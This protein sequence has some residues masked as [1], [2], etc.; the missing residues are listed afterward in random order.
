MSGGASS[1]GL[2]TA[3]VNYRLL[4]RGSAMNAPCSL[5]KARHWRATFIAPDSLAA[6][7]VWASYF[8]RVP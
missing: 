7:S 2:L 6:S 4:G 5:D 1:N 3:R 8:R